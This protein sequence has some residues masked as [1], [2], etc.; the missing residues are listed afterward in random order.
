MYNGIVRQK[1]PK[2]CAEPVSWQ[3]KSVAGVVPAPAG[4]ASALYAGLEHFI[5][6][7]FKAEEPSQS[8]AG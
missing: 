1:K 6:D 8:F 3:P 5:G 4:G 2:K 7:G